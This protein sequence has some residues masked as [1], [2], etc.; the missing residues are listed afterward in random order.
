MRGWI[1]ELFGHSAELNTTPPF[2]TCVKK[3]ILILERFLLVVFILGIV[4]CWPYLIEMAAQDPGYHDFLMRLLKA[5]GI[6][7]MILI[8]AMLLFVGY[9]SFA[10]AFFLF[11]G[12][13]IAAFLYVLY[14]LEAP[15]LEVG[16]Q[17]GMGNLVNFYFNVL[18]AVMVSP[19]PAFLSA[20]LM[21]GI[22]HIVNHFD[23]HAGQ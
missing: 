18:V 12:A 20:G 21:E 1:T 10:S 6:V 3:I 11:L 16:T 22:S 13:D 9:R 17:I 15:L 19:A 7:N 4:F 2:G 8:F 23:P 5:G 14:H